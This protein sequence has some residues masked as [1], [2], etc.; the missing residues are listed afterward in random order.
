MTLKVFIMLLALVA[1][2]EETRAEECSTE[3]MLERVHL[4]FEGDR[5]LPNMISRRVKLCIH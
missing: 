4:L 1:L 5:L 2:G 3:E